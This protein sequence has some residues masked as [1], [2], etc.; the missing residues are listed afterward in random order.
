MGTLFEKER[1]HTD[2][3]PMKRSSTKPLILAR[4]TY[5][6]SR[7]SLPRPHPVSTKVTSIRNHLIESSRNYQPPD[8]RH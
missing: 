8:F 5:Q 4:P 3:R 6:Q 2:F 7:K 1:R